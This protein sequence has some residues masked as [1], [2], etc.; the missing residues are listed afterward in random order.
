VRDP[1]AALLVVA[2]LVPAVDLVRHGEPLG[3]LLVIYWMQLVTIGFWNIPKLIIIARWMA[4]VYVP[5]FIIMYLQMLAFFAFIAFGLLEDQLRGTAW[6][7]EFSVWDYWLP[8]ALFFTAH[9]ASFF[10]NY[11]GHREWEEQSVEDHVLGVLR[12]I[13]PMSLAAFVGGFL[14]SIF[15]NA[16]IAALFVLPVKVLLDVAAHR[17]ERGPPSNRR[18]PP[19]PD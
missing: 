4:L 16:A 10:M 14:G 2:N 12:R 1:T 3:V 7:D 8:T 11:L 13:F 5:V 18:R 15:T 17:A 9:G 19:D 6:M